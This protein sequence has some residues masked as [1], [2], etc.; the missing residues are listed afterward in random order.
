[1]IFI[2]TFTIHPDIHTPAHAI[3]DLFEPLIGFIWNSRQRREGKKLL[4][5]MWPV[6][7]SSRMIFASQSIFR[8]TLLSSGALVHRKWLFFSTVANCNLSMCRCDDRL[9][10]NWFSDV[11]CDSSGLDWNMTQYNPKIHTN[12]NTILIC[13]RLD[14]FCFEVLPFKRCYNASNN[15]TGR[16]CLFDRLQ[17]DSAFRFP[18]INLGVLLYYSIVNFIE[19][20]RLASRF[21][22]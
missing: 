6:E 5:N 19:S 9:G 17:I 20:V 21:I 14:H 15:H 10:V 12:T 22:R 3:H 4:W 11:C 2:A 18:S 7:T 8:A 1:M 16:V 13:H